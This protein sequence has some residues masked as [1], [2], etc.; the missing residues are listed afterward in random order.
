MIIKSSVF[1]FLTLG[2][3]FFREEF[4]PQLNSLP[5]NFGSIFE[6]R[7]VVRL[8]GGAHE[9]QILF[10]VLSLLLLLQ[11]VAYTQI[12]SLRNQN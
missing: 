12:F 11:A 6:S 10:V 2:L 7:S 3:T 8:P 9:Q 4:F 1:Y 5:Y